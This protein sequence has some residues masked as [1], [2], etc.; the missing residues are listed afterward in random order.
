M[1][2][3]FTSIIHQCDNTL[4]QITVTYPVVRELLIVFLVLFVFPQ[5]FLA[6]QSRSPTPLLQVSSI[7]LQHTTRTLSQPT[8]T[9][10]RQY[11]HNLSI[12]TSM[13]LTH[14]YSTNVCITQSTSHTQTHKPITHNTSHSLLQSHTSLNHTLT[15]TH[16]LNRSLTHSPFITLIDTVSTRHTVCQSL[17]L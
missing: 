3:P 17:I 11:H 9:C 5:L 7:R 1:H 4:S 13:Y 15:H 2:Y 8:C 12:N 14:I 10:T 16:T 6:Y